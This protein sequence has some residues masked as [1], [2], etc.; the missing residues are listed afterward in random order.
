MECEYTIFVVN[1]HFI[2]GKK[3][4]YSYLRDK[5]RRYYS[6]AMKN[7]KA[8]FIFF[9]RFLVSLHKIIILCQTASFDEYLLRLMP[10]CSFRLFY[11][12]I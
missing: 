4:F 1:N 3:G 7:I 11:G 5:S 10:Y 12:G 6:L 9:I 2:F 8:S